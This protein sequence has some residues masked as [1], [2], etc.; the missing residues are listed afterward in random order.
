MLATAIINIVKS[1]KN[2]ITPLGKSIETTPFNQIIFPTIL[3]LLGLLPLL[4]KVF[5]KSKSSKLL[6]S[7]I[8]L[9]KIFFCEA[10]SP[11]QAAKKLVPKKPVE[12]PYLKYNPHLNNLEPDKIL[13]LKNILLIGRSGFGKTKEIAE[14]LVKLNTNYS[15]Q[16]VALKPRYEFLLF[17]DLKS[18]P[19]TEEIKKKLGLFFLMILHRFQLKI[20]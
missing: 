20:I 14:I 18:W 15:E 6:T 4:R 2:D 11:L 17:S 19:N 10:S 8:N 9:N 16:S 3:F 5:L 7:S 1:I 13:D 12:I